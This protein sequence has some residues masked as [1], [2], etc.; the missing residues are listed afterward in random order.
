MNK[1][2]LHLD[3]IYLVEGRRMP[4]FNIH[5]QIFI[6]VIFVISIFYHIDILLLIPIYMNNFDLISQY[7][8][9]KIKHYQLR[10]KSGLY[11]DYFAYIKHHEVT[12]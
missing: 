12:Q 1:I 6:E 9:I 5:V 3:I 10:E 7:V 11:W 4:R 8:K 2:I